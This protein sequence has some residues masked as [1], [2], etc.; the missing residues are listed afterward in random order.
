VNYSM[1]PKTQKIIENKEGIY[2]RPQKAGGRFVMD[3]K[4]VDFGYLK[5]LG[6]KFNVYVVLSRHA[7]YDAQGCFISYETLMKESGIFSRNDISRA[8]KTLVALNMIAVLKIDGI[9]SNS[10]YLIDCNRW[11]PLT[12]IDVNTGTTVSKSVQ[13]QYQKATKTSIDANTESKLRKETKEVNKDN[14]EVLEKTRKQ[15]EE[16]LGWKTRDNPQ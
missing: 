14:I 15:L 10:Y 8:L 5:F 16:K 1:N 13:N 6:K 9:V 4:I 3:N 12:S 7:H 11:R 2:I